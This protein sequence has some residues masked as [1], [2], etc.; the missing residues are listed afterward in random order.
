ML[1]GSS[2]QYEKTLNPIEET[3]ARIWSIALSTDRI[4][5]N[6]NFF[7]LG[8]HSIM[9][10]RVISALR[11]EF[12]VLGGKIIGAG[13]GGCMMLY[14]PRDHHRLARF[15]QEHH[16]PRLDYSV[17]FEGAKVVTDLYASKNMS[18]NHTYDPNDLTRM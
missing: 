15:M 3:V 12:G 18:L 5:R 2:D 9:A 8:G 6:D 11:K 1:P 13:G 10:V 17:A 14:C 4:G 16:M 7:D